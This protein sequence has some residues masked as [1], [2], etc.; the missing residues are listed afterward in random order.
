LDLLEEMGVM[1]AAEGATP[2]DVL[3]GGGAAAASASPES[4]DGPY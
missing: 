3:S 4:A 2:R 1:G